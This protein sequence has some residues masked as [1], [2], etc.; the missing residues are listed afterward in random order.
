MR[1]FVYKQAQ[2]TMYILL[3][4]HQNP[5][6]NHNI[7]RDN[8]YFENVVQFRYLGMTIT[9]ENLIQEEI[10]RSLNSGNACFHSVQNFCLLVCCGGRAPSF[11][12]L[13]LDGVQ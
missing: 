11:S 3:S 4:H 12:T 5:G 13:D 1:A 6:Q 7:N 9:N 10:K 8:R 2:K